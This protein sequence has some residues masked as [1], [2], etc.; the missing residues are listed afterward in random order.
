M[1]LAFCAAMALALLSASTIAASTARTAATP[2]GLKPGDASPPL[3]FAS[4][5]QAPP[6]NRISLTGLRGK[7]VVLEFWATW[8]GPCVVEMPHLNALADAFQGRVQ[9]ISIDDEAPAVVQRFLPKQ[10]IHGWLAFDPTRRVFTRYHVRSRPTTV[11]IGRSGRVLMV[12]TPRDVTPAVLTAA[13]QTRSPAAKLAETMIPVR[14][15][16]ASTEP[17]ALLSISIRAAPLSEHFV[18][19]SDDAKVTILNGHPLDIIGLTFNAQP[20]EIS[21]AGTLPNQGYDIQTDG[22]GV[23]EAEILEAT[24]HAFAAMLGLRVHWEDQTR[25][26]FDL[27]LAPA[28]PVALAATTSTHGE[29]AS[30]QDD[31]LHDVKVSM[32]DLAAHLGRVLGTQV[33]DTTDLSGRYDVDF[34]VKARDMADM[35]RALAPLG[36]R[37]VSD[38]RVLRTLVVNKP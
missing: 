36:L 33:V 35:Q 2:G 22:P 19:G 15:A 25:D 32:K 8:C 37:L 4:T 21:V 38:R 11:V 20:T 18:M 17:A 34:K 26:V 30:Y 29:Y 28:T 6:A 7:V 9:F 13:L 16:P 12:G 24:G 1:K 23:K 3:A 27:V 5:L 31:H 14:A 10:P